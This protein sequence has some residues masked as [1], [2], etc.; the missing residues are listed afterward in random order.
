MDVPGTPQLTILTIVSLS[1]TVVVKAGANRVVA[2][3]AALSPA[4]VTIVAPGP[5]PG[6]LAG[7]EVRTVLCHD[8]NTQSDRG[9]KRQHVAAQIAAHA[10]HFQHL[11]D[12][13]FLVD[14]GIKCDLR[15]LYSHQEPEVDGLGRI[16]M[17]PIG[18]TLEPRGMQHVVVSRHLHP[19]QAIPAGRGPVGAHDEIDRLRVVRRFPGRR[20]QW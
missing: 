18:Q 12:G 4:A 13:W 5:G 19:C 10:T 8:G 17:I 6:F 2:T 14:W 7:S 1:S 16:E 3:V 15:Q 9:G 11:C 20:P